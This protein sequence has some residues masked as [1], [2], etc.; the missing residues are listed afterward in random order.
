MDYSLL[1][2]EILQL[3]KQLMTHDEKPLTE[4]LADD[5]L[6]FGSSGSTYN[7]KAQLDA[8]SGHQSSNSIPFTIT[9]FS[10][11]LLA[12]DVV[13]ATYQTC[14]HTENIH[15]LRS[16]IWKKNNG[17]WQMFFHQGTPTTATY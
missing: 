15:A 17:K 11:K 2:E 8:L 9:N 12:P 7:K 3:E 4:L 1:T 6:E 13:L 14:K 10:V 16:S 5:F